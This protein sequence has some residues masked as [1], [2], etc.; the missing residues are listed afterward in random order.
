[1]RLLNKVTLI[2]GAGKGIGAA[3]AKKFAEEGSKIVLV[4]VNQEDLDHTADEINEMGREVLKVIADVTKR[5]EV[6]NLY[7]K[8]VDHFG[9]VD[10][11]INNAGIV[12]DAQLLKMTEDQW[13]NVIDVNLKG[14]FNI[15]QEAATLMKEQGSGV[16]LNA[17]SVVG[18]YGNFGQTNYAAAKWG[19]NGMTKTWAKELGKHGIRVNAV[20][21]GFI[22]TEMTEALPEKVLEVM[23]KKS[24]LNSM[25]TPEDIANGYAFL[26][27]DD[28]KFITGTIL[29]IDGGLVI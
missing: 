24:P 17:S 8:S 19:V 22:K 26:A 5:S 16:I 13:D 2:T 7:K 9:S 21:P 1:M 14:V 25:G 18:T 10:V 4:D 23:K 12:Q 27:S 29:S 20:A 3:T 15:A 6:S 11:V 28:A